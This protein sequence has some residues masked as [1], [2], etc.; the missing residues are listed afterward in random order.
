M[1]LSV[2]SRARP[3]TGR[4]SQLQDADRQGTK[5]AEGM[6]FRVVPGTGAAVSAPPSNTAPPRVLAVAG[7]APGVGA[8]AIT[9]SL[10]LAMTELGRRVLVVDR[11]GPL[12]RPRA[13]RPAVRSHLVTRLVREASRYDLLLVDLPAGRGFAAEAV[14]ARAD[15]VIL[16]TTPDPDV[17]REAR[18]GLVFFSGFHPGGLHIVVN[19]SRSED[20]ARRTF[21]RLLPSGSLRHSR[22]SFLGGIPEDP[23][24]PQALS[25]QRPFVAHDPL[26]PSSCSVRALAWRLLAGTLPEGE[27]QVIDP[28]PDGRIPD[29]ANAA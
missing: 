5:R 24:V 28:R 18:A 10:G 29:E 9:A 4:G 22:P 13:S 11:P 21:R 2:T 8:S 16:V 23:A 19:R 25:L 12:A 7:A 15:L 6:P 26:A 27:A 17:T 20:G 1:S 14:V 3:G